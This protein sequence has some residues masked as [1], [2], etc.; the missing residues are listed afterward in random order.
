MKY[1]MHHIQITVRD[2][3]VSEKFYDQLFA[4][5]GFDIE[6]KYKGYLE[7]A[8]M[9]VVEYLSDAFDFAICSPKE[10][11]RDEVIDPRKPGAMQHM[12]FKAKSREAVD[13]IFHKLKD[14][15]IKILHGKP[16]EYK[17]RIAPGYYALFFE[18]PDGLRF[19]VFYYP[20]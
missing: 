1:K 5:L 3:E 6:K 16:K 9:H 8:D 19:E 2:V 13:E 20:D 17:E 10:V 12:A 15:N 11:Y 14:L 7:H 18:A 4:F